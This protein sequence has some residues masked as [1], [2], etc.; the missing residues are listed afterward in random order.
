MIGSVV[1]TVTSYSDT[2]VVVEA[3]GL[4]AGQQDVK[5]GGTNGFALDG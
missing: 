1:A 5:V 4:S 2:E 3:S